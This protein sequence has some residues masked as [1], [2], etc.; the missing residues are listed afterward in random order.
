MKSLLNHYLKSRFEEK[1]MSSFTTTNKRKILEKIK[2]NISLKTLLFVILLL[3]FVGVVSAV[4]YN[5]MFIKSHI[6]VTP[7]L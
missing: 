4:V 6:G 7:T 3:I 1:K 5:A 2:E